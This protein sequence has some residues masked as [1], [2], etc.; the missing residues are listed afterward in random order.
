MSRL[1]LDAGA[2]IALERS[3]RSM[4]RRFNRALTQGADIIT[5]A[6]ILGQ[7]WRKPER[8]AVL[9]R[10]LPSI[11]VRSLTPELARAAGELLAASG[12]ADVLDGALALLCHPGDMVLTSDPH[13]LGLLVTERGVAGVDV[14]R[15]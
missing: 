2:L 1:V 10:A 6:G 13:D 3:Q 9:A 15:V 5:H 14:V 7:V 4:W 12:T 11:D 8:Q